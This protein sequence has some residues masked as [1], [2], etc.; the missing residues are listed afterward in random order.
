MEYHYSNIISTINLYDD[1]TDCP[2]LPGHVRG[3]LHAVYL[4]SPPK[5]RALLYCMDQPWCMQCVDSMLIII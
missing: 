1:T 5:V 4:I 2:L 3:D